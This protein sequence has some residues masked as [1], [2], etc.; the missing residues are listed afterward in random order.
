MSAEVSAALVDY[1][2][3]GS[4]VSISLNEPDKRNGLSRVM[5]EKLVEA[6]VRLDQEPD[7]R[8]AILT[9]TGSAFSAGGDPRRMLAPGLY[10]D[11]S[12]SELRRFYKTGIQRMP[13]AF[14]NLE[15]PIIAAV[16]GPAIGAGGD[17]ACWCDLRIASEKATFAFS[18]V[19]LGLVPGDGGAWLLPRLTGLANAAEML[20]TGDPIDAPT[21][22]K[23]GLVSRVVRAEDLMNQATEMAERIAANP[24][25]SVRLTKRLIAESQ[26]LSLGSGLELAATMQS[27]CHKM[28]DH[29][30]AVTARIEKRSGKYTGK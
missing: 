24:P 13:L 15:C 3:E 27:M 4:I 8:C 6:L 12:T 19:K 21:A 23:V 11:M 5:V 2:K 29:R 25:H 26:N 14:R 28:A 30:E 16:N 22:L 17:L 10:P 9:G 20:L 7:V 18:F 1:R